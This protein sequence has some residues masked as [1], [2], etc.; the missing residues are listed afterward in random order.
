MGKVKQALIAAQESRL[1][2][3]DMPDLIDQALSDAQRDF[4]SMA[5]DDT[6]PEWVQLN[7][8]LWEGQHGIGTFTQW[9]VAGGKARG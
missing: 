3:E 8:D 6:I 1:W 7:L 5:D 2:A 4:Y 9:D